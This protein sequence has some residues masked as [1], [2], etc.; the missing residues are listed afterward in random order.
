MPFFWDSIQ[1]SSKHASFFFENQLQFGLLPDNIDSGHPPFVGYYLAMCWELFGRTLSVSHT[2]FLPF[3]FCILACCLRYVQIHSKD[4][5]LILPLSVFLLSDPYLWAQSAIMS[6][7]IIL[8]AGFLLIL[9]FRKNTLP[10]LIGALL[11]A[12]VSSRGAMLLAACMTVE[13]MR[14]IRHSGWNFPAIFKSV[15]PYFPGALLFLIFNIWHYSEKGWIGYHADSP[16]APCFERVDVQGFLKNI[17]ILGWRMADFGRIVLLGFVLISGVY[18]GK[19]WRISQQ[20]LLIF[21]GIMCI[22]LLPS[23]LIYAGLNAHRY[24]WPIMMIFNFMAVKTLLDFSGYKQILWASIGMIAVNVSAH[25]WVYPDRISQGWDVT[26]AHVPYQ[27]LVD[28]CVKH[29]EDAGINRESIGTAFPAINSEY[30]IWLGDDTRTMKSRSPD[31]DAYILY[32]NVM[33]DFSDEELD[34]L[35]S[36]FE[37]IYYTERNRIKVILYK[38]TE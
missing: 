37:A 17:L 22:F 36:D 28:N 25:L 35:K 26:L 1:L 21:L 23:F 7:D 4:S 24:V 12:A 32:S 19:K 31:T 30:H 18:F 15:L 5:L 33:N 20:E 27:K 13:C 14:I 16:W 34:R 10:V 11:L 29:A 6:P 9:V 2:A 38:R 3:I 8:M